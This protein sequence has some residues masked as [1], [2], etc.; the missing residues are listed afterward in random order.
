M[1]EATV[2][3]LCK[4]FGY[5]RV[6]A[7]TRA[8]AHVATSMRYSSS[9]GK[10]K[11]LKA[12]SLNVRDDDGPR[13]GGAEKDLRELFLWPRLLV[14]CAIR[15]RGIMAPLPSPAAAGEADGRE[16]LRL[17]ARRASKLM[18]LAPRAKSRKAGRRRRGDGGGGD[19]RSST[20][21]LEASKFA[22]G[23]GSCDFG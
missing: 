13:E 5:E 1:G 2:L 16:L 21:G 18:P 11:K 4:A 12:I 7:W 19:A 23:G 20:S 3:H 9:T 6:Y 10:G 8:P 17:R 15:L 22:V 14:Q